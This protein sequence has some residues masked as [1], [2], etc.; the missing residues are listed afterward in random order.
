M[1]SLSFLRVEWWTTIFVFQSS[2]YLCPVA[3]VRMSKEKTCSMVWT[4][5]LCLIMSPCLL[6]GWSLSVVCWV[7]YGG[8][9]FVLLCP[10]PLG[11]F[12]HSVG[13]WPLNGR[14]IAD[15]VLAWECRLLFSTTSYNERRTNNVSSAFF[16]ST[17]GIFS[18]SSTYVCVC[19]LQ[20]VFA[21]HAS[22]LA[23]CVCVCMRVYYLRFSIQS[24]QEQTTTTEY[25][26]LR[27][28]NKQTNPIKQSL[29]NNHHTPLEKSERKNL[30]ALSSRQ[31]ISQQNEA[32]LR[33]TNHNVYF[34]F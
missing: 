31:S 5:G 16:L 26:P 2:C 12:L 8:C 22:P 23:V 19:V 10:Q 33:K 29:N 1:F 7:V 9:M 34:Y 14:E 28:E 13:L 30:S 15:Y 32:D 25:L 18:S 20:F 24:C 21:L 11:F 27:K 17:F 6:L 3:N 4:N